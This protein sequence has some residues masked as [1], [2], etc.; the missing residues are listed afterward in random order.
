MIDEPVKVS[1]TGSPLRRK[2]MN[3]VYV[4]NQCVKCENDI[5]I[6]KNQDGSMNAY[7]MHCDFILKFSKEEVES[8]EM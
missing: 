2:V 7:C 8:L 1:M 6:E 4:P 3:F 5:Q